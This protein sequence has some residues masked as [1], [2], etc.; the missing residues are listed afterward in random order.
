MKKTN[1]LNSTYTVYSTIKNTISPSLLYKNKKLTENQVKYAL[2]V[3]R[4]ANLI[5][6][7]GKGVW[8]LTT[9]EL[10]EKELTDTLK[11]HTHV[12]KTYTP[13]IGG[14]LK[15]DI[16]RGHAFMVR[17]KLPKIKD[18]EDRESIMKKAGIHYDKIPQGQRISFYGIRKIWL[19]N[20][21]I[22]IYLPQSWFGD[23]AKK[24][25][26]DV[27]SY[28]EDLIKRLE[29]HLH[30]STF[31]INRRYWIRL[32]RKHYALIKNG[33]AKDMRKHGKNKFEVRDEKG[34]LW[35]IIDNSFN[36]DET[37]CVNPIS[38][39]AD[40]DEVVGASLNDW[41][42]GFTPRF[43]AQQISHVTDNQENFAKHLVSHVSAIQTLGEQ[44]GKLSVL[45]DIL[46]ELKET[47]KTAILRQTE[48]DMIHIQFTEDTESFMGF[49]AGNERAYESKKKGDTLYVEKLT[50]DML[51]KND[52][53]RVIL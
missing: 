46:T 7:I 43:L 10:T 22:V 48:A 19:C 38:A 13:Q 17:L 44:V 1:T 37:E 5:R 16:V 45:G 29:K 50:A 40:T 30:V 33:I 27:M 3:L 39:V 14:K 52:K 32:T 49:L 36:L 51:V 8:E 21:S 31:T 24:V 23:S 20:N 25:E 18:W 4:K 11:K 15:S 47:V 6:K 26:E 35:L 12:T 28:T 34:E 42:S 2:I 9:V 41:R 53:A